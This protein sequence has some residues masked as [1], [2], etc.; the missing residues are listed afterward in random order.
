MVG[1]AG[2]AD[3]VA[4]VG[5]AGGGDVVVV[6]VVAAAAALGTDFQI[7]FWLILDPVKISIFETG[8]LL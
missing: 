7:V 8:R 6:V 1:I 3:V 5:I 2:G 4:V